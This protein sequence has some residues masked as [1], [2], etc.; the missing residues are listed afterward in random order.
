MPEP[1]WDP[2]PS[3][4]PAPPGWQFW[5]E[6]PVTSQTPYQ[7][8][9]SGLQTTPLMGTPSSAGAHELRIFLSY[10]RTD[11][12]AQANGL[13]DGLRNRLPDVRVFMDIDGI[14]AGVDFEEYIKR[15]IS[16]CDLVMV[17]IGDNWLDARP[18]SEVRRIDEEE[19]FVRL[20][21]ESALAS[22]QVRTLPVLVEG[23]QMPRSVDLPDTIARLGRFNAIELSDTRW[24][25]DLDRL[26]DVVETIG[27]ELGK[28]ADAPGSDPIPPRPE[29]ARTEPTPP[30][31][32]AQSD[33][34]S[35][36]MPKALVWMPLYTVGLGSW[37][38]ALWAGLKRPS[39]DPTRAKLF[40]VS[41]ALAVVTIAG[42]AMVGGSPEDAEGNATGVL[43][44]VGVALMFLVMFAGMAVAFV[45]RRPPAP[46]P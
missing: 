24:R 37:V 18:G 42:F 45:F 29:P 6:E 13:Y 3:W 22:P 8:P 41:A 7:V 35:P 26:V 40:A 14:P 20:E 32:E 10:R 2:D 17:M 15:E 19:D 33:A 36:S 12:Q 11:C 5:V 43:S 34:P 28:I 46:H 31:P 4:G 16:V 30:R 1:G 25:S 23:A 44:N 27:R 9:A 38:P 21:I 39:G